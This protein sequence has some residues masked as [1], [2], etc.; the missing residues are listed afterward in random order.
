MWS[1][2]KNQ[3][4]LSGTILA[5]FGLFFLL[6]QY[7]F[8]PLED[9]YSWPA[10]LVIIGLGFLLQGYMG[11]DHDSIL[12]GAILAGIGIHF[13]IADTLDVWPAHEGIFLLAVAIGI[14]LKYVK[15]G[16]GLFQGILFLAG[17][18]LVLFF[19]RLAVWASGKGLDMDMFGQ[20]WPFAFLAAGVY[21][22]LANRRKR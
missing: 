5:G 15:T 8:T 13:L 1:I 17:S 14:L 4:Y 3:S 20:L 7:H 6:R 12:P 19:D 21:F 22:L 18:I 9:F 11:K 10:L 16:A 2:L